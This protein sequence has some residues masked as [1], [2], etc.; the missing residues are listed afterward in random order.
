[1]TTPINWRDIQ[2]IASYLVPG[3]YGVEKIKAIKDLRGITNKGLKEAKDMIDAVAA[4]PV[5]PSQTDERTALYAGVLRD[6]LLS[7][8]YLILAS[9][10][11]AG[12]SKVGSEAWVTANTAPT[13]DEE[14]KV[15]TLMHRHM[16]AQSI[17][18]GQ[19]LEAIHEQ[20]E[21]LKDLVEAVAE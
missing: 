2:V 1:M 14:L 6:K 10:G 16:T 12:D 21:L 17:M 5:P 20:N 8:G 15:A 19:L 18:I 13:T 4:V 3:Q 9:G 11:D 7:E